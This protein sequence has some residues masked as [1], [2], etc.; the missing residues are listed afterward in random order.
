MPI[1][2]HQSRRGSATTATRSKIR[3]NINSSNASYQLARPAPVPDCRCN[4]HTTLYN[5]YC[6]L[7]ESKLEGTPATRART[8]A[9]RDRSRPSQ[10]SA[11]CTHMEHRHSPP[12]YA[13]SCC[14]PL[15]PS[16]RCI[17]ENGST[18]E[19]FYEALKRAQGVDE[20][21][22]FFL[23]ILLAVSTFEAFVTVMKEAADKK[24]RS[25]E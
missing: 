19:Y 15:R 16:R 20:C 23:E 13:A 5:E 7:F 18:P 12:P 2:R 4:R 17:A 9:A 22:T 11:R 24:R 21:H 10:S 6:K 14:R 8:H 3:Q 1:S 25:A